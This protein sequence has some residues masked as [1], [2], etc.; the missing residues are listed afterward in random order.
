MPRISQGKA[1]EAASRASLNTWL[2]LGNILHVCLLWFSGKSHFTAKIVFFA[3]LPTS[4]KNTQ[5]TPYHAQ[6]QRW[7]IY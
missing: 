6:G 2:L 3:P 1:R 4:T 5:Y 7:Q